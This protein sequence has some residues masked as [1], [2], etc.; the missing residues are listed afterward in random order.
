MIDKH[1]YMDN[2]A[3][4]IEG[5]YSEYALGNP[6]S[7]H[8]YGLNSRN[9]IELCKRKICKS[10]HSSDG[11]I[12]FTSGATESNN[13]AILGVAKANKDKKHFIT[14][15]IEHSSVLA[16][17]K[18]LED[19]GCRVTY[20]D[21]DKYGIVSLE[22][23]KSA[24]IPGETLLVSIMYANNEIGTIQNIHEIGKICKENKIY[25]HT[26]AVQA[27][28]NVD[29][30][31][32]K[33]NIDLMSMSAHKVFSGC[34]GVGMLYIRNNVKVSPIICGGNQEYGLRPGTENFTGI[35]QLYGTLSFL[36]ETLFI[37]NNRETSYLCDR[38]NANEIKFTIN[39]S[40]TQ[41]LPNILSLTFDNVNHETLATLLCRDGFCVSTGSACNS[42][43]LENS[44]VL[45]AIG[46]HN[47]A[48]RVSFS[49][50]FDLTYIDRFVEALLYILKE[51]QN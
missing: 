31:V 15:K 34:S 32:D 20:L 50:R 44:H 8:S 47:G 12:V 48:I 39:G 23:I 36:P 43:K 25:F 17:F 42:S 24:I 26:D 4:K 49:R 5:N 14:S 7:A 40:T 13:L 29:I 3:T 28:C 9:I 18:E 19:N 41:A 27:F 33:D 22:D 11:K 51:I 10:I 38:L 1:I 37:N 45:E 46:Q 2:A 35:A 6:S 21:V 16:C 30:D